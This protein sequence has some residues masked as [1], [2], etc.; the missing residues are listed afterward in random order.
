MQCEY[1]CECDVYVSTFCVLV[2]FQFGELFQ[3]KRLVSA[4]SS[5]AGVAVKSGHTVKYRN[6][7]V[8]ACV[9]ACVCVCV[10]VCVCL[11]VCVCVC[12]RVCV[13]AEH[14]FPVMG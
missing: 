9:H 12:V 10:C 2:K 1:E 6:G 5:R 3:V 8:R 13:H 11:C 7:H 4:D 14:T